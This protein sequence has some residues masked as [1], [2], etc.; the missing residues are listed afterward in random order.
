M[1]F[2]GKLK[3]RLFKSSSKIEEGLDAIVEE[4]GE[5][6]EVADAIADVETAVAPPVTVEIIPGPPPSARSRASISV[7]LTRRRGIY[8]AGT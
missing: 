2:F 7:S 5:V 8:S 6:E 4:G 1:S 3:E